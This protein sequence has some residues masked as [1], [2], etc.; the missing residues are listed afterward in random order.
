[1]RSYNLLVRQSHLLM[2]RLL[3]TVSGDEM[4]FIY[5]V[6]SVFER[7]GCTSHG[8]KAAVTEIVATAENDVMH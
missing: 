6:M 3:A 4:R 7:D 2:V 1:M 8:F 5:F